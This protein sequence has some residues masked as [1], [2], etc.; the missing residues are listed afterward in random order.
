MGKQINK[1]NRLNAANELMTYSQNGN[2]KRW[3]K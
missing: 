1:N 3:N 2:V